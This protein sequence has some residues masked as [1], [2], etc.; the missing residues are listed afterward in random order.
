MKFSPDI[1]H[2]LLWFWLDF[3]KVLVLSGC[4]GFAFYKVFTVFE[5]ARKDNKRVKM[6]IC[7]SVG[8]FA[9]YVFLMGI[10]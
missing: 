2:K 8:C 3:L 4:C 7:L 1:G 6:W 5:K 10:K 9:L